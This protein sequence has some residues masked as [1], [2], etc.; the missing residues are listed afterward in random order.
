MIR[1]A[2]WL[3]VLAAG[4]PGAAAASGWS[5]GGT[6]GVGYDDNAAN[7]GDPA[8]IRETTAA[9]AS[10]GASWERRFGRYTALQAQAAL[11]GER[12]FE[13][14]RLSSAGVSTR[15]RLLHKPGRGF[16]TPVLAVWLGVGARDYGSRI[17]DASE[18]R[19]GAWAAVPL[20]TAVQLRAETQWS[21]AE[22]NGAV[23]DLGY[24]SWALNVDWL[25]TQR[26]T[27]YAN[28]RFNDGE[29]AVSADEARQYVEDIA[30]AEA[31]DPA[32]GDG[33]WAYRVDGRMWIATLGVN[34][35]LTADVALDVQVRRSDAQASGFSYERG[36]ASVG[37]LVRW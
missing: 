23:F 21:Q 9:F 37:V 32:F 10:A 7:A 31:R 33:W 20:T 19:A 36:L 30:T 18:Y 25:A 1:L 8:D 17:R 14:E 16:Y 29:F 34:A 12:V 4:M 6:L 24:S 15:V 28:A 3:A 5:F 13:L 35:P 22:A 26:V 11:S 27:V 2:A